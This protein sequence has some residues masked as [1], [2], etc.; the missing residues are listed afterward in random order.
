MVNFYSVICNNGHVEQLALT[1]P[2]ILVVGSNTLTGTQRNHCLAQGLLSR[3]WQ[4]SYELFPKI[5]FLWKD[6]LINVSFLFVNY[7]LY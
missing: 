1:V 3:S 2:G 6:L 7:S 5:K 4:D